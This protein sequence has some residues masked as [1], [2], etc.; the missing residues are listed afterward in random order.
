MPDKISYHRSKA[1][2]HIITADEETATYA[3]VT[4]VSGT[5]LT[6]D[7]SFSLSCRSDADGT[8][9][10]GGLKAVY[11]QSGSL[12]GS[13]RVSNGTASLA[14]DDKLDVIGFFHSIE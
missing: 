1:I 2:Q 11:S 3:D 4:I 13:L 8:E 12:A 6:G 14:E 7:L 5:T 10:A 9:K